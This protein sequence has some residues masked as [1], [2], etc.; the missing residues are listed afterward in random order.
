MSWHEQPSRSSRPQSFIAS[1]SD[2]FEP[3]CFSIAA[4]YAFHIFFCSSR[5]ASVISTN[6]PRLSILHSRRAASP[7]STRRS[8]SRD[9]EY[10][11]ISICLSSSTG[12]NSPD[13]ARDNSSSASYHASGG[14]PAFFRSCSTAS[15]T[16]VWTRIRRIQAAVASVDGLRFMDSCSSQGILYL[17][18]CICINLDLFMHMH[19]IARP[20][21]S[22][23]PLKA[24]ETSA[25][26]ISRKET[27]HEAL[28]L[29]RRL[30]ALPPYCAPGSGSSLRSGQGR[31]EGQDPR[32]R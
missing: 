29:A 3:T 20:T 31:S 25:I 4:E 9:V 28:L 8:I 23:L 11:G 30:F 26:I 16:R 15:S 12:R 14:K 18:E 22:K 19:L 10:C 1:A 21:K 27:P 2:S 5:P 17:T 24:P 6:W 32:E 7:S 13:G